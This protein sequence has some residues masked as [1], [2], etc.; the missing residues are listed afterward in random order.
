MTITFSINEKL[1]NEFFSELDKIAD[2]VKYDVESHTWIYRL[3]PA[4]VS[5]YGFEKTIEF[6]VNKLGINIPLRALEHLKKIS[7][8]P[9]HVFVDLKDD[10][11]HLYPLNTSVLG[12]LLE[13]GIVRYDLISKV[14]KARI[15]ALHM[16]LDHL[17]E[18]GY[19]VKLGF[20]I[21]YRASFKSFFSIALKTYQ[22][23]AYKAWKEAGCRGI[24][25]M[26]VGAGRM[27]IALKAIDELKVRTVI[28]VPSIDSL[29]KWVGYLV[30]YLNVS[31]K[32]IGVFGGGRR[33]IKEIT[34]MT[35]DMASSNLWKVPTYFGLLIADECHFA[36]SD[37]Y[38]NALNNV[39]APYRLGLTQ[40]PNRDDGLHRYY[41]AV[42]GPIVY[43]IS[44]NEFREKKC[45]RSP[46]GFIVHVG[47][48]R[49]EYEEYKRLMKMYL[50]Y[51]RSVYPSTRD[52]GERFRRVLELSPLDQGAREALR[53]RLKARKIV[54]NIDRKI[55]VVERLLK[56]FEN[57][58]ILIFSKYPGVV[59][60]IARQ[61]LIPR[62][63]PDTPEDEKRVYLK[64]FRYGDIRVLATSII[65]D[66][67]FDN[68]PEPN[69]AIVVSG[70]I[71]GRDY[72]KRILEI[73]KPGD[74]QPLLIEIVT[75]IGKIEPSIE[76]KEAEQNM[77]VA[78]Q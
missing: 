33:E 66:K 51:C 75:K 62:I 36:V 68:F 29:Y 21:D 31:L 32:D 58:K 7:S 65:F 27:A 43:S 3:N 34:V 67:T 74:K 5:F 72:V 8:E 11:L 20:Q 56:R 55:R 15:R 71:P 13:M 16:I 45:F 69:V 14:F 52:I 61:L 1:N 59:R 12:S 46:K 24:V 6:I 73:L 4:K 39:T 78:S 22:E 70:V 37:T 28:L 48:S 60:R 76:M 63:L 26:P 57:E 77:Q 18:G 35:Y 40:T 23:E 47:L 42:L 50:N 10:A 2:I 41:K 44:L 38:R 49:E 9:I 64:M 53:A 30:K 19:R 17:N 54:L 25:V